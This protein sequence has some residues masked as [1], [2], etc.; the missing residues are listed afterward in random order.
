MSVFIALNYCLKLSLNKNNQVWL[1]SMFKQIP[2]LLIFLLIFPSPCYSENKE[3]IQQ[4][5]EQTSNYLTDYYSQEN[6]INPEDLTINYLPCKNSSP[7]CI[8]LLTQRA[9]NH[10]PELLTIEQR[11]K[12]ISE[13]L[14]LMEEKIDYSQKKTWTNYITLDPIRLIQNIFGG[15]DLQRDRIAITDLELSVGQLEAAK[16][17]LERQKERQKG[18]VEAEVLRLVLSYESSLRRR[19]LVF[20]QLANFQKQQQI[21]LIGYRL[22]SGSTN[23][24]LASQLRGEQLQNSLFEVENQLNQNLREIY[25]LTGYEINQEDFQWTSFDSGNRIDSFFQDC[26]KTV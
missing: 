18:V 22:G 9:I 23:Q 11:I 26:R 13:R 20:S 4:F 6:V 7:E 3:E 21:E 2:L 5:I 16:A 12:I 15:G 8:K 14:E 24:Y 1:L 25:Q 17:E 19:D 10:S